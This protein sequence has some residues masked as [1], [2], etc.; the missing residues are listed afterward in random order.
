[1]ECLTGVILALALAG[2]GTI[3]GLDRKRPSDGARKPAA[4]QTES[5]GWIAV[6][7]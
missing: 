3:I 1:M 5:A 2:F 6:W 4:A 7:P